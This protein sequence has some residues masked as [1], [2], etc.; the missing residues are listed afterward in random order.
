MPRFSILETSMNAHAVKSLREGLLGV[1]FWQ[2]APYVCAGIECST[3]ASVLLR[4]EK[5]P[6][7]KTL[8]VADPTKQDRQITLR[9][10]AEPEYTATVDTKGSDGGTTIIKL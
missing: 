4:E 1:N 9:M 7:R 8:A 10:L 3:Q 2:E 5:E 6:G